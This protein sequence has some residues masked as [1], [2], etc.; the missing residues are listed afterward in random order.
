MQRIVCLLFWIRNSLAF[1]GLIHACVARLVIVCLFVCHPDRYACWHSY[2]FTL[3]RR[4]QS[5][6]REA[7]ARLHTF[8]L[9]FFFFFFFFFFVFL[10]FVFS[11]FFFFFFMFWSGWV[12]EPQPI[13]PNASPEDILQYARQ[14]GN[15]WIAH[16]KRTEAAFD[17]RG[18]DYGR[19]LVNT[20]PS[21]Y[22]L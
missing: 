21:Q 7:N 13:F 2:I 3:H 1:V 17:K 10:V 16:S 18:R 19:W 5:I 8:F 15:Q 9:S 20:A 6:F 22:S 14:W 4:T 12:N 11:S